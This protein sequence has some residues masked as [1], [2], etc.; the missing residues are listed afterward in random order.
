MLRR[1]A[2]PSRGVLNNVDNTSIVLREATPDEVREW[3][4]LVARFPN[5]R[6]FHKTSWLRYIQTVT[7]SRPVHL[8]FEREGEI[9]GCFPGFLIKMSFLRVFGSPMVGWQTQSMGPAFYVDRISTREMFA[10]LVPF[11][12][13][14][15]QIHHIELAN[16]HL[17]HEVMDSFGFR[18]KPVFTYRVALSPGNE[19]Q[20]MKNMQPNTR[21]QLRKAM[22][23]GL[24]AHIERDE[25]FVNEY[26]DQ[27][28]EVFTRKGYAVPFS[29]NRVL[30]FFRHMKESNN[31][32]A[33]SIRK[34]DDG[35]CI[36][37]GMFMIEGKEL[38]LWGWTHRARYR[39]HCPT[40]LL[41]W[42]AMQKGME[43]G[44]STFDMGGGGEA[45]VK[46]GAMHDRTIYQWMW[47]R[48]RWLGSLRDAAE[49]AYRTQ[50]SV[51]G[52]VARKISFATRDSSSA[53]GSS[54]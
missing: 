3:D 1:G 26:Y 52:R 12:Q 10:T 49:R 51:R 9:V 41:T 37:S 33:I 13:A 54:G 17:D 16:A 34:P 24:V 21:N 4:L 28:V 38:H 43:V 53:H 42:T 19:Q 36:A 31:L 6:L 2:L 27:M 18:G 39:W 45:K 29:R 40:E 48:Y 5:H 25:S 23:L 20:T 7:G 32:L 46:F 8:V 11:L 35:V 50:Q 44:C 15:Y 30:Q 47:S 14:R 22:K